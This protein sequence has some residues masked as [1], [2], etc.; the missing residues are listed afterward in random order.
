MREGLSGEGNSHAMQ[1]IQEH[2]K[3][4]S[5]WP[6]AM[7]SGPQ[8]LILGENQPG[9]CFKACQ[10]TSLIKIPLVRSEGSTPFPVRRGGWEV[11]GVLCLCRWGRQWIQRVDMPG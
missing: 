7:V 4:F 3:T 1:Y 5:I 11:N 2:D 8:T 9:F 10:N 6:K